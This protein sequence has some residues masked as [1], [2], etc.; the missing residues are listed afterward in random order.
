[1]DKRHLELFLILFFISGLT[2]GQ[3][4][5]IDFSDDPA[6]SFIA[7]GNSVFSKR[8]NPEDSNDSVG[9]FFN[10]GSDFWQGFFI[11]LASPIDLDLQKTIQ[12][13]FY[14][15]DPDAHTILLKLENGGANPDVQ[16]NVNTNGFGWKNDITF[17]FANAVLGSDGTT[18]INAS[19]TYSRLVIFIDGGTNKSGTYLIDDIEDVAVPQNP[20]AIDVEYTDLVW[21]DE[22]DINGAVNSTKWH[23]QTVGPNGG[24]WYNNEEQHYTNSLTNSKVEDDCLYITAK[25]ETITQNGVELD[26]TSARLNSKFAFTYGRIDVRAKLPEGDGTWPAIW[27]LGKNINEPGGFWQPTYGT[28]G[29]PACGEIDIMEHGLGAIN[30]VSSALHTPCTGC[31]GNTMNYKSKVLTDVANNFHVYSVNWSPDQITFLIDNVGYYT[32]NPSVKD[33][34]TWPFTQDQY[35]L[36]NVAMGG[37]AGTIDP[38]FNLSSMVIDYVR[39]YQN[40]ILNIGENSKQEFK[41]YPNPISDI[42]NIKE[43]RDIDK[44]EIY[45]LIGNLVIGKEKPNHTINISNINSGIYLLKI[46]S[47]NDVTIKKI[48]KR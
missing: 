45:N 34:S 40:N 13:D 5:P 31:N 29:W 10:D 23:H 2:F 39:V 47:D 16:V 43:I 14:Q 3:Q 27:T 36:L 21:A 8:N 18:A 41:I 35:I 25:S 38:S 42:I 9:Q 46:Y 17:D 48:I 24:R 1:M 32:Y 22:F 30:H 44:I 19:G 12:L 37:T 26:Y 7:F 28:V 15:F 6:D 33:A 11:D 20:N 4:M